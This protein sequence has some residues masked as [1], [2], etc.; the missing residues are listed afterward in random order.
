MIND[1]VFLS[2]ESGELDDSMIDI[3][4]L[5]PDIVDDLS[6]REELDDNTMDDEVPADVP[7]HIEIHHA[8]Q[9]ET[10]ARRGVRT[11]RRP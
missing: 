11:L 4:E 7:G 2:G 8:A 1:E 9:E 3:V 10:P 6:D 5:P